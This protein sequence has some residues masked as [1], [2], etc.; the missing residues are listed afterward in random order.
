MLGLVKEK[1]FQL[2]LIMTY[3]ERIFK[4][5]DP[6]TSAKSNSKSRPFTERLGVQECD[7]KSSA[8]S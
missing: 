7:G 8:Q 4:T 6:P 2:Q 3:S 5:D 1:S